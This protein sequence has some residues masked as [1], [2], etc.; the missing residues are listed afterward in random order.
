MLAPRIVAC[1]DV[2][3]GRV[4]K[5]TQ[6]VDLRDAGDP[7]E[8]AE[9]LRAGTARTR[10]PS[11]TS[12]PPPRSAHRCS[13]WPAAPPND[14]SFR[15]PSAAACARSDDV[16]RALRAGADKVS[17]QLGAGPGSGAVLRVRRAL[18][19]PV[20][21]G[22]HRRQAR[23]ATAGRWWWAADGRRRSWTRWSGPGSASGAARG[24]CSS[25]ASTATGA[26][27]LR[28]GAHPRGDPCGAGSGGRLRRRGRG[29]ARPRSAFKNAGADA[30]LV[31][32]I[33]HDGTTTVRALKQALSASGVQV[34]GE[35]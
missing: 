32:G 28:P 6:F 20:R 7:V 25:P 23:R 16:E 26:H 2:K 9:A 18:R 4:V 8:L 30:A 33:L 19:G 29:R 1:L 10:S 12:P 35:A 15:S 21:G 22:E 17:T 34:R 27:R 24:R 31:A 5:G 11:S 14:S 3:G 13:T